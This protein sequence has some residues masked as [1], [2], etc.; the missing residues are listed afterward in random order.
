MQYDHFNAT[1]STDF[2]HFT[3]N[4]KAASLSNHNEAD[5]HIDLCFSHHKYSTFINKY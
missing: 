3:G 5:W 2:R 4:S 1:I